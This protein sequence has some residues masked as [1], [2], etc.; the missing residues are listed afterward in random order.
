MST[1][2]FGPNFANGTPLNLAMTGT[3]ANDMS[4]ALVSD[5][6]QTGRANTVTVTASWPASTGAAKPTGVVA[7][8]GNSTCASGEPVAATWQTITECSDSRIVAL[9]PDGSGAAGVI[10]FRNLPWGDSHLR[11]I[12]TPTSG[13]AGVALTISVNGKE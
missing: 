12:Y 4:E 6:V 2:G 3:S 7:V 11:A 5:T 8:Q 1:Q 9:Q 13:G 10:K